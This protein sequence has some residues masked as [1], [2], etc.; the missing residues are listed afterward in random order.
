M[1]DLELIG[2]R[3]LTDEQ[4]ND[5]RGLGFVVNTDYDEVRAVYVVTEG[6]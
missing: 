1:R 4:M 3:T 5:L 6:E 2:M